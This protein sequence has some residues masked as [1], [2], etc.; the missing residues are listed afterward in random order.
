MADIDTH[1][2]S[3]SDGG[4]DVFLSPRSSGASKRSVQSV[5]TVREDQQQPE[6]EPHDHDVRRSTV[7]RRET[8]IGEGLIDASG[9]R[10]STASATVTTPRSSRSRRPCTAARTRTTPRPPSSTSS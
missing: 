6:T 7:S 2:S 8:W 3:S 10:P 9:P 4:G 1:S 5:P